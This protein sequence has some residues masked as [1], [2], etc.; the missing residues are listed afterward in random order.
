MP[1][2]DGMSG[3]S[4]WTKEKEVERKLTAM[5]IDYFEEVGRDLRKRK[6]SSRGSTGEEEKGKIGDCIG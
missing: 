1:A 4:V 2:G 3:A 6:K 5:V